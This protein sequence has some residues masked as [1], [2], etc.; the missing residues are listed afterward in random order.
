VAVTLTHT[1]ALAGQAGGYLTFTNHG[2]SACKLTGW[3]TVVGLTGA[4]KSAALA[5]A[6]ST[7]FGAWQFTAPMPVVTLAPGHAAYAVVAG[8]SIPA[9][10]S[11]KCP[12]PIKRLR[13]TIPGGS[14]VSTLSAWLPGAGTYLPACTVMSGAAGDKISD[15]VPVSA[16]AH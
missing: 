12:D 11:G 5:H 13:V 3:P 4:G 1:G 2:G 6:T 15:I 7:M 16:V 9:G 10:A 8:D 14:A